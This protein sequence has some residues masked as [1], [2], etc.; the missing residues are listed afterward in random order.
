MIRQLVVKN[1]S[2]IPLI[3]Q[4]PACGAFVEVVRLVLRFAAKAFT[5]HAPD[6]DSILGD[7]HAGLDAKEGQPVHERAE[8]LAVSPLCLGAK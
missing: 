6:D 4:L 3:D 1:L 5:V 8:G 7:T 2:E